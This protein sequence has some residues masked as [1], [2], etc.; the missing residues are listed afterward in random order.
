[1]DERLLMSKKDTFKCFKTS[2]EV[3]HQAVMLYVRVAFSQNGGV[4][5]Q[6]KEQCR[7]LSRDEFEL[8]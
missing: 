5:A 2:R 7:C 4:F 6:N 8:G 1:M 3:I